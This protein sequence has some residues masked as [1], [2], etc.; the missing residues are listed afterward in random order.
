M[1]TLQIL[2][3]ASI[4]GTVILFLTASYLNG[5]QNK[6]QE[7]RT[8]IYHLQEQG[9]SQAWAEHIALVE[10]NI[11]PADSLYIAIEED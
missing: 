5:Q 3:I 7:I 4:L 9:Y 6:D 10:L 1:R 2:I 8:K 11:I